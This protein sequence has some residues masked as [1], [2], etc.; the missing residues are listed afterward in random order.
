MGQIF[1]HKKTHVK[2]GDLYPPAE[3]VNTSSGSRKKSQGDNAF[4]GFLFYGKIIDVWV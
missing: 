4:L 3:V 1:G 2:A